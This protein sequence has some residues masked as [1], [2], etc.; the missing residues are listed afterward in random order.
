MNRAVLSLFLYCASVPAWAGDD[1]SKDRAVNQE[2][3]RLYKQMSPPPPE[4]PA[5]AVYT[6]T[7][8]PP[9]SGS[10]G[11]NTTV[12]ETVKSADKWVQKNLW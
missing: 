4:P 3:E 6:Q 10:T 2:L 8:S 7:Y 11:G 1:L 12:L 9:S 5:P